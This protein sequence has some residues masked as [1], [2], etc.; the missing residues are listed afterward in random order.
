MELCEFHDRIYGKYEGQL[1]VLEPAWDSFRPIESVAWN[2]TV[3]EI[4]DSKFKKNLFDSYYGYGSL[5]QKALCRRLIQETELENAV[6]IQDPIDFWKWCGIKS[7][8]W[9]HDRPCVFSSPCVSRDVQSWKRYLRYLNVR[10]KTLKN[11]V[12]SRVT[13][14]LV[15]K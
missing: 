13:K 5:Q 10:A 4:Q 9:W 8:K 2:G 15:A 1:Y 7:A 14:R 3:F 12:R 11:K 6:T